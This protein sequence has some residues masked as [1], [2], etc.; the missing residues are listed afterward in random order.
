MSISWVATRRQTPSRS[1]G[2]TMSIHGK[3]MCWCI[4]VTA[5]MVMSCISPRTALSL[6]EAMLLP[7]GMSFVKFPGSDVLLC[8]TEV[9][10]AQFRE[11]RKSHNSGK[12]HNVTLAD[13]GMP[14]VNVSWHDAAAFCDWLAKESRASV[15]DGCRFRLPTE[16]EW[17]VAA[18]CGDG[19]RFPWGKTFPVAYGNY[20]DMSF[21]RSFPDITESEVYLPSSS[22]VSTYEDGSA[23]ACRVTDAGVNE[24]GIKGLSGNVGEWC[25]G[26]ADGTA[27]EQNER[28]VKGLS[29]SQGGYGDMYEL[30]SRFVVRADLK[31]VDIGFRVVATMK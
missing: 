24:W 10:N 7:N 8:V 19:R 16:S 25:S 9:S 23:V 15:P 3:L 13:D 27:L 17:I 30:E 5:V 11:F 21:K 28:V 14:V 20:A 22:R 4:A 12:W 26:S 29:W 1:C 6:P 18:S 2:E 31:D